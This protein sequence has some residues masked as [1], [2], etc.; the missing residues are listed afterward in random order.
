MR[1]K[2]GKLL[3]KG[4]QI[5]TYM[6][7]LMTI[8]D[9]TTKPDIGDYMTASTDKGDSC[10][11]AQDECACEVQK[12]RPWKELAQEALQVQNASNLSGVSKTFPEV[13]REVRTRLEAEGK[14]SNDALH[15]HPIIQVWVDKLASL[16]GTQGS[17]NA[18]PAYNVVHDLAEQK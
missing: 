12:V 1:D 14:G 18:I 4:D 10:G 7:G 15:S 13:V 3:N 2:N 9:I 11:Y 5:V 17:W 6:H 16:T 8:T